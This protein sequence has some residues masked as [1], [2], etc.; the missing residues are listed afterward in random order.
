MKEYQMLVNGE[1]GDYGIVARIDRDNLRLSTV[2]SC[3][4]AYPTVKAYENSV[5]S[6]VNDYYG[7]QE[8]LMC[9]D[10]LKVADRAVS[11]WYLSEQ[12]RYLRQHGGDR[13][14]P[15]QFKLRY[16]EIRDFDDSLDGL[17]ADLLGEQT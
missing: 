7:E 12:V 14:K 5:E 3:G 2:D 16:V 1:N 8:M 6:C 15:I 17:L 4:G 11:I 13:D 9:T 10:I